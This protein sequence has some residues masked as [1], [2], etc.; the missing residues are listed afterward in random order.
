[1][2]LAFVA[3]V[4]EGVEAALFL[5]AAA[6]GVSG[7]GVVIGAVAGTALAC[8]LAYLVYAGGRTLPLR[9]FFKVTGL[10]LIVFAAGLLSRGVMLL[11]S[12]GDL[13]SFNLNGVYDLRSIG[14]LTQSSEIGKFLAAMVGW[15]PR[16]SLEQVVLWL[17][18]AIP[19]TVLFLRRPRATEKRDAV[20]GDPV[21]ASGALTASES[22]AVPPMCEALIGARAPGRASTAL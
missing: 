4:R 3:V 15:D 8:V 22:A 11:Q 10:V 1:M 13:G 7:W 21:V 16:P 5:V 20:V 2:L 12:A 14:W 19:V 17:G 9:T 18:Y 6:T